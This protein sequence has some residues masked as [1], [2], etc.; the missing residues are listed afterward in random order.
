MRAC[1]SLGFELTTRAIDPARDDRATR[2]SY[3]AANKIDE[4]RWRF[5]SPPDRDA[6]LNRGAVLRSGGPAGN[7]AG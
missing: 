4:S 2:K 6:A 5:V 1:L 7:L 3:A